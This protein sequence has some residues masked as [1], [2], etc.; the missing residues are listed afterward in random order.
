MTI[1]IIPYATLLLAIRIVSIIFIGL[2]IMRQLEL[3]KM[4]IDAEVRR[5]RIVLF[6]LALGVFAGNLV[7][8][9][10]DVLT[11]FNANHI[12]RPPQIGMTSFAYTL[13]AS[14]TSLVS[15]LMIW[16]LYNLARGGKD[17]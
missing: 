1:D 16:K 7:P 4:P 10:I 14:L 15:S 6:L 13:S 8:T 17:V 3:F 12:G 5:F 11:I 2:V 9:T